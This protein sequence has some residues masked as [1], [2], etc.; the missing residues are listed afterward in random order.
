M[1]YGANG[2]T[3]K[4][5]AQQAARDGLRPILAGRNRE[6]IENLGHELDLETRVF[7][8][9]EETTIDHNLGG[10][11]AVLHCAGPFSRTAKPMAEACIRNR[12]HYL[13]ITGEIGVFESLARRSEHANKAGVMLLPGVGFDVVPTDCL[14]AY[15]KQRLPSATRLTLAIRN[16]GGVSRGTTLTA[17]E[18]MHLGGAVR[19]NGKIIQVPSAWRTRHIDFGR[20]EVKC[21]TIPWG[22]VST[23]FHSTGIPNIQVYA[24]FPQSMQNMMLASRYLGGVLA[25][26]PVQNYLKRQIV[27]RI[28]GPSTQERERGL[29]LVWGQVEDDTGNRVTARMKTPEGYALTVATSLEAVRRVLE[30]NV[31][32]GFQTPSRAFGADFIMQFSGVTREIV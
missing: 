27:K 12:V 2:Y 10:V 3:G 22:D 11:S 13:D 4:I 18:G 23:A 16:I 7:S 31:Q 9:D 32:P 24:A 17:F 19:H 28:T 29:S 21:V 1:I 5:A 25:L 8:L 20:G 6:Q 15:L 30:G 14:A 26:R